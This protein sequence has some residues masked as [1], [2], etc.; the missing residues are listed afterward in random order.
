MLAWE[1]VSSIELSGFRDDRALAEG[2]RRFRCPRHR[3]TLEQAADDLRA[4]IENSALTPEPI[5]RIDAAYEKLKAELEVAR[6]AAPQDGA[7]R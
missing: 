4:Q 3:R 1:C 2:A 6:F 7:D 5:R